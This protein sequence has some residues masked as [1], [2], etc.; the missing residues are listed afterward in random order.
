MRFKLK[1]IKAAVYTVQV[2]IIHFIIVINAYSH[3]NFIQELGNVRSTDGPYAL[4]DDYVVSIAQ[5]I[6]SAIMKNLSLPNQSIGWKIFQIYV[7]PILLSVSVGWNTVNRR[8]VSI[9][10]KVQ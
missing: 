8:T 5:N 4:H 6:S 3:S 10:E 1:R 2:L 7:Q 9:L